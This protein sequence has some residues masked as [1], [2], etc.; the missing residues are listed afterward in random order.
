MTT[1]M[2][3]ILLI[4]SIVLQPVDPVDRPWKVLHYESWW[5]APPWHPEGLEWQLCTGIVFFSLLIVFISYTWTGN[6]TFVIRFSRTLILT[7]IQDINQI[8]LTFSIV[9]QELYLPYMIRSKMK[10]LQNSLIDG[11]E[12]ADQSL[13]NFVDK[14]MRDLDKRAYLE[15]KH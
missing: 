12:S 8:S 1:K 10:L 13:L 15:V 5:K 3:K 11:E 2:Q 14:S 4:D 7:C 9:F 6:M